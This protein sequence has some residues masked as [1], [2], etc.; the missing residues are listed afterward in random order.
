MDEFKGKLVVIPAAG[1]CYSGG[2]DR[3]EPGFIRNP[4]IRSRL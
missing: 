1:L 3:Y 2:D 4:S